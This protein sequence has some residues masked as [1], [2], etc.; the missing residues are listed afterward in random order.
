MIEFLVGCL[1]G[2]LVVVVDGWLWLR[3]PRRRS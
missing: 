2:A 1:L 3:R